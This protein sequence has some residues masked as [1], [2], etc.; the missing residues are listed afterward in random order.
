MM[1]T[2]ATLW[3]PTMAFSASH[4]FQSPASSVHLRSCL[5]LT[6]RTTASKP[7]APATKRCSTIRM[8]SRF[9][10]GKYIREDYLV[11]KVSAKEVQELVKGERTVP[12]VVDFYATW[13]GPC[14]LMAQEL[15]TLAVEY[16]GNALFV[17][18]DTDDEYEF[19][20]DMQVRGLPTLYFISPDPNK[21][22]I[23][24]E[25]LVPPE[26]IKN[27]IDNEM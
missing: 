21:D 24:T 26:M 16:E 11:K 4:R 25:G 15:E 18:V 17:K 2:A 19:A 8:V 9:P 23:R 7:L 20:R 6:C 12:L 22:A 14:I 13:C 27:I 3:S 10:N 1:T 5:G